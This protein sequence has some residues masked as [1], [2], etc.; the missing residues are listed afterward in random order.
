MH[1][2]SLTNKDN[3]LWFCICYRIV[4]PLARTLDT[5]PELRDNC[6]DTLASLVIQFGPKFQVFIPMVQRVIKKHNIKHS[7][8]D[9]LILYKCKDDYFSEGDDSEIIQLSR[10][11]QRTYSRSR[12]MMGLTPMDTFSINRVRAV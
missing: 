7:R 12:N 1:L 10:I 4:H 9:T 5:T 3:T 2:E 8:Y 11:N 6:M